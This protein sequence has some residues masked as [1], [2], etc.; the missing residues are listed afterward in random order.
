MRPTST[1][2]ARLLAPLLLL[3]TAMAL[4]GTARADDASVQTA[5]RLL[6]YVA[7]EYPG[8]VAN[9]RVTSQSEFAE[10]REFSAS[11]TQRLGALPAN[12]A[13]AELVAEARALEAAVG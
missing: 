10:M 4:P 3:L 12:P 1:F 2:A 13:K 7:V 8:A 5:W 11:V 9:G 6:D